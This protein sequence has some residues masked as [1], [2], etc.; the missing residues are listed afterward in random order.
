MNPSVQGLQLV[1]SL[2]IYI[3]HL[4]FI[5]FLITLKVSSVIFKL[6]LCTLLSSYKNNGVF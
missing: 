6:K 1:F 5:S 4:S 2:K 3:K